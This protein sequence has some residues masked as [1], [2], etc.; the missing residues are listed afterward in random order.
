MTASCFSRK[1]NVVKEKGKAMSTIT[2]DYP[3]TIQLRRSSNIRSWIILI[4]TLTLVMGVILASTSVKADTPPSSSL[5]SVAVV[6]V[7]IA[8]TIDSHVLPVLAA[9]PTINP[10]IISIPVPTPP[11]Q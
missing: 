7:L 4:A 2:F 8:P 6:P 9:T 5:S 1:V 3:N 11:S 10:A